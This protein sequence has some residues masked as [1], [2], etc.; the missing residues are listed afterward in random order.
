MMG[1]GEAQTNS[2]SVRRGLGIRTPSHDDV[3][4]GYDRDHTGADMHRVGEG[5]RT[6]I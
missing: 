1:E 3:N 5:P 2:S 4:G 6:A